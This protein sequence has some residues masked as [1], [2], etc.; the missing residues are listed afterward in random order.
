MC[1]LLKA[2]LLYV[3]IFMVSSMI[4]LS[5]SELVGSVQIQI[6]CLWEI[7]LIEDSTLWKQ[8]RLNFILRS[9][10]FVPTVCW[11]RLLQEKGSGNAI[12]LLVCNT[13]CVC[14]NGAVH[15]FVG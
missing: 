7:M 12:L 3:V 8:C 1:S 13:T 14:E 6:I 5:F 15:S 4:L 2:Q 11:N 9:T 10:K